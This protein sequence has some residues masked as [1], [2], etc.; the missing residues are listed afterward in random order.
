MKKF[1]VG[2]LCGVLLAVPAGVYASNQLSAYLFPSKITIHEDGLTTN[3][4]SA[5]NPFINYNN[6]VYVP[7]R[8][9]SE[10]MGRYV[11][12]ESASATNGNINKI[13]IYELKSVPV[14]AQ[15]KDGYVSLYL[16]N[17]T[18]LAD[19]NIKVT[20]LIKINKDVSGKTVSFANQCVISNLLTQPL[21]EGQTRDFTA[22]MEVDD[23]ASYPVTVKGWDTPSPFT[24][25]MIAGPTAEL[26]LRF[27]GK[28]ADQSISIGKGYYEEDSISVLNAADKPLKL[29]S[30]KLTYIIYKVENGKDKLVCSYNVPEFDGGSLAFPASTGS[31]L[32]LPAWDFKDLNGNLVS[33]GKYAIQLSMPANFEYTIDGKDKTLPIKE[34][35]WNERYEFTLVN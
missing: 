22:S 18:K 23:V 8:A 29:S 32:T 10:A 35:M 11:N 9:F 14:S 5:G 17:K 1:I 31:Q 25:G 4:D 2:F 16:I 12:F 27:A 19:G 33:P 21:Q 34:N 26:A 13:D 3:F 6:R 15:D 20:G 28:P 7:L 30:M 24:K